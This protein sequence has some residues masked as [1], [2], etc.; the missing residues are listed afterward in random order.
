[1]KMVPLGD[2]VQKSGSRAK[3]DTDFQV[4]SVTKHDGFVP[5]EQYFKK[6]VFSKDLSSYTRVKAGEFAYATIH[7]DEGSIGIAPVDCLISPMYTVFAVD[8][9]VADSDYLI[10]L[11]K[12]PP[13]IAQYDR[14]GNGSVHRRRSIPLAA[15]GQL[16]VPLPP[17]DE[18]RRIAAIL[19][20]ADAIRQKRRQAIAHL[21]S[22]AQSIFYASFGD[23]LANN[24]HRQTA[25]IGSLAEVVTGSSP[26]RANPANFGTKIEWLKSDNLGPE[27]ATIADEKLSELGRSK[28]R[29]APSGSVLVTCIAG[30][31]RSIGKS[32]IVDRDVT[33]NQQINAV[34]PSRIVDPIFLLWQL[35]TA[36]ELVRAKSTGG[37]KGLVNKSAF[38]SIEILLPSLLE[39]LEFRA[40][41]ERIRNIRAAQNEMRQAE[42]RLFASLQSRAF[43]GEL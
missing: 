21:D 6:Q 36:P 8:Q 14:L 22:L 19:D 26:S 18:Q 11:L 38:K 39:Q 43:R 32:S 35:K 12:S 16:N 34:L 2:I 20:K 3:N 5:S 42:E 33:F 40:S 4:Y 15:L 25:S 10:R 29:N 27:T 9:T 37:M 17:L 31:A 24:R 13:A 1:M 41:I 28:A 30:S 7:L 23:P